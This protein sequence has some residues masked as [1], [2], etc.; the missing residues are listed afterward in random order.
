MDDYELFLNKVADFHGHI[1]T[2]IVLGTRMTLAAMRYLHLDPHQK[3]RNLLA[4]TEID[5]CMADAVMIITGC[6]LGRR[7][8]KH[9]DYGK[10]AATLVDQEA[11]KAVRATVAQD[12]SGRRDMEETRKIISAIPDEQ[13]I[14]LRAVQV[15]IPGYDLPG[16]PLKTAVCSICGEQIMDGRDI[17]RGGRA[18]CRG[19]AHGSYYTVA[20]QQQS[21]LGEGHGV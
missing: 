15:N 9:V 1:C 14:A 5:R 8:L 20:A 6:S 21:Q 12:F 4:Y 2:G 3:N 16:F 18:I 13:L 17:A 10:F 11:G 19:C 7:T